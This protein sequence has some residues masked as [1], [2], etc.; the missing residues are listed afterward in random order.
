MS[1]PKAA[2]NDAVT[3]FVEDFEIDTGE[4]IYSP[5]EHER[6]VLEEGIRTFLAYREMDGMTTEP[7]AQ[8]HDWY[9]TDGNMC[10]K[11][12][13]CARC[14]S[15]KGSPAGDAACEIAQAAPAARPLVFRKSPAMTEAARQV[16]E[17]GRRK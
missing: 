17:E 5:T 7:A 3:E 12:T 15:H 13:R 11:V 8:P 14:G 16:R 10:D 1:E 2:F 9:D 4:G 6:F